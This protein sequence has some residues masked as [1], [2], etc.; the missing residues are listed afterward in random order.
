MGQPSQG[1]SG[2]SGGGG[3]GGGSGGE[4]DGEDRDLTFSRLREEVSSVVE[5]EIQSR[6]SAYEVSDEEYLSVSHQAWA[7]FLS[8]ASQYHQSGV[9]PLGLVC[10]GPTGLVCLIKKAGF[11]FLRPVDA[12]EQMVISGQGQGMGVS[13]TY[14]Y[15]SK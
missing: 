15:Y 1:A 10:D 8:C 12:L 11:S 2:S 5:T 14:S 9:S 13:R 6:V 3:G 7:R 4:D